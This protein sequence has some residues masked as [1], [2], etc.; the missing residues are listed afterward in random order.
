VPAGH[1]PQVGPLVDVA[2]AMAHVP[3]RAESYPT[4]PKKKPKP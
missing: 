2:P 1:D 3:V 4:E